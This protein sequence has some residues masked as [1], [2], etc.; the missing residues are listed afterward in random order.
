[1]EKRKMPSLSGLS[2]FTTRFENPNDVE[3]PHIEDNTGIVPLLSE[4]KEKKRKLKQEQELEKLA[5]LSKEC[6]S[7]YLFS[8]YFVFI[9]LWHEFC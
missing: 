5:K 4:M 2:E 8:C 3:Y 1:M 7:S 9:R 6:T